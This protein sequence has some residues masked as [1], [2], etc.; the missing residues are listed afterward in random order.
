MESLWDLPTMAILFISLYFEI[1]LLVTYIERRQKLR[2]NLS[3]SV[4]SKP[5]P[6]V[7]IIV[8]CFN[9]EKTAASTINSLLG[10]DYPKDKLQIVLV[11]DG[12]K[13]GTAAVLESFKD[14]PNV[15][16]IHKENGG[17]HTALN[18]GIART[19]SDFVGCLDADSYATPDSLQRIIH[20]FENPKVMA[21]VPS[22]HV[23]K[24]GTMIQRMQKIEYLIGIFFRS[25]LA[26][27]DSLYVTPGP[28]SIFRREVFEM[29]GPYKKAHNTEDMEM[30][31]RMQKHGLKIVCAHDAVIYTSSPNTVKKLYKQRVRW[32]SGFLHTAN[33]YRFM[34]FK[35]QYG[36]MGGFVLPIIVISTACVLYVT[37]AFIYHLFEYFRA[38]IIHF[39][40][41]GLKA[42]EWSWPSFNW[43]YLRTTPLMFSSLVAVVV[44]V[45]F[46]IIGSKLSRGNR[47]SLFDIVCYAFLYSLIAPIWIIKSIYNVA[48]S[49]QVAWR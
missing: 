22:L 27:L 49:R 43:F 33:D 48:F 45:S 11:N 7:S 29:I 28:L 30:A 8:P 2:N 36:H 12:S 5:F 25:I 10:L 13:D 24:A 3:L 21:V 6:S 18:L 17:K 19:K 40:A 35:T 37:T 20:R 34:F 41:L 31:F 44:V 23:H 26:E 46:L 42:F 9:E 16:I 38:T 32:T 15:S 39:Q 1:F 47:Y 14:Q 4:N